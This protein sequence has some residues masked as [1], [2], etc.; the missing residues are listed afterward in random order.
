[1]TEIEYKELL[2][3]ELLE[4]VELKKFLLSVEIEKVTSLEQ[5]KDIINKQQK[6]LQIERN[7]NKLLYKRLQESIND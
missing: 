2:N 5:A 1:M 4:I 6:M 7:L 3:E